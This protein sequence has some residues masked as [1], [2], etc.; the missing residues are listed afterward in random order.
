[1]NERPDG[2]QII[3]GDRLA[4]KR[5]EDNAMPR[6]ILSICSPRL[7]MRAI[8]VAL[9]DHGEIDP[10]RGTTYTVFCALLSTAFSFQATCY[11]P[12]SEEESPEYCGE[13]IQALR[14]ELQIVVIHNL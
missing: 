10:G 6:S 8:S 11:R 7:Q 2:T 5:S 13:E 4:V 9:L 12:H 3:F 1:M 14:V